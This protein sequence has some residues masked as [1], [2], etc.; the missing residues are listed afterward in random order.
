MSCIFR[1]DLMW[2]MIS[3][4]SLLPYIL[5]ITYLLYFS[6]AF[7]TLATSL[8]ISTHRNWEYSLLAYIFIYP[9]YKGMLRSVRYYAIIMETLRLNY[10]ESY[11]PES[12]WHNAPR[13]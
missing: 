10:E 2:L 9:I 13:W 3:H 1:D 7:I 12:A 6:S 4:L 11:L 5:G 8:F